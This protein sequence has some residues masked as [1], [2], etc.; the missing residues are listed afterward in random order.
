MP[1]NTFSADRIFFANLKAEK[2]T[3][4]FDD[5]LK[6]KASFAMYEGTGAAS[7]DIKEIS[8]NP[9]VS[10][11]VRVTDINITPLVQDLNRD[12]YISGIIDI[13]GKGFVNEPGPDMELVFRSKKKRG[14]EQ[15]MNF[16]AISFIASF[17]GGNP[18]KA[19][20][21]SDLGYNMMAGRV[22]INEGYLT[23]EGLAGQDGH[24]QFLIRGG[25][26]GGV[27]LA[28]D[29]DSNTIKIQR[30]KN[31]IDEAIRRIK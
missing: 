25:T 19:F 22:T 24:R 20:G 27:N 28:I 31:R 18:I 4:S 5:E 16:G 3:G 2:I 8:P 21:S 12:I 10:Y 26:F 9:P 15:L 29:K 7:Y 6:G 11:S 23:I 14:V 1:E 30:L 17:G 13:D